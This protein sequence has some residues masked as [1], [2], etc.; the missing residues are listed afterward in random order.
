M[1]R[2]TKSFDAI[3]LSL[4]DSSTLS[5][6]L[7]SSAMQACSP[8]CV[9]EVLEHHKKEA[10]DMQLLV[11]NRER[12][13]NKQPRGLHSIVSERIALH[14]PALLG[15]QP[16]RS[17]FTLNLIRPLERSGRN[18]VPTLRSPSSSG[19]ARAQLC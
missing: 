15:L 1:M 5:S 14:G 2:T 11:D 6:K 7:E 18:G 12:L 4:E 3:R 19:T 16:G 8:V 9:G 10:E 13:R 17:L